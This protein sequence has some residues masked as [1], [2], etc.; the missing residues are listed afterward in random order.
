MATP[1]YDWQKWAV[2]TE[3]A[4][5]DIRKRL[6]VLEQQV[7]PEIIAKLNDLQIVGRLS[8]EKLS[9]LMQWAD[10]AMDQLHKLTQNNLDEAQVTELDKKLKTAKEALDKAVKAQSSP[11]GPT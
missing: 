2:E 1:V 5:E 6:R 3:A 9:A 4:I 11:P 10:L 7:S 8:N